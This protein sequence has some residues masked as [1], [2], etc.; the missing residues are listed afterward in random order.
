MSK[1]KSDATKITATATN[2]AVKVASSPPVAPAKVSDG[3]DGVDDGGTRSIIKGAKLKFSKTEEWIGEDDDV[4]PPD[5]EF[6]VVELAKVTQKWIDDKPAETRILAPDEYFPDTEKLNAE[7][8]PEEWR[9]KFGKQ[10][11]PWQNS[12][13]AYL[14]DPKTMEG[15]TWPTSTAG[16]FRAI[17]ELKGHVRRAR[18]MQGA[19]VYPVVTLADTHMRTQFGGRQR[20]QFKVVR[21][22]TLGGTERPLLEQTKPEPMNDSIQY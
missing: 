12:I 11:G 19:N 17:D 2:E 20:P 3:F 14:L 1:T 7:A 21:F 18:M 15:F 16:G 4:I 8:P 6:I 10:V 5:R 9:D 13:V 22:V